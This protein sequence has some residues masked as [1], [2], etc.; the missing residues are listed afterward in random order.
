MADGKRYL[1]WRNANGVTETIDELDP[2]DFESYRDF[3]KE[4][5][6]LSREYAMSGM[7]QTR[8]SQR[9][10]SGW[11]DADRTRPFEP[12]KA[13]PMIQRIR[14][15]GASRRPSVTLADLVAVRD[16]M[17]AKRREQG[18]RD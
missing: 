14:K 12:P 8:W 10:C 7:A 17:L 16:R 18:E 2:S 5:R 13:D 3:A 9:P 15:R 1:N 6:R 11:E 4:K